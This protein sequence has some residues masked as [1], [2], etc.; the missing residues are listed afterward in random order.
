MNALSPS[1]EFGSFNIGA[2]LEMSDFQSIAAILMEEARISLAPQKATLVRSRLA[3][4]LREKGLNSYRDYIDL[5]RRDTNERRLMVEALT[6]NHTHFFR[7]SHHFD[8]LRDKLIP[9]LRSQSPAKPIR[10]WSSASS[11]GEEVYTIAMCLLGKDGREAQWA[12][13]ADL[14]LLATDISGEMVEATRK[15]TYSI[16]NA[17]AIPEPYR[18]LWTREKGDQMVMADE[19]RELVS[20]MELNLFDRWP[21]QR[22]FDAIFC[23]N[24]M[25]YFDEDAKIEL[26]T[27]LV[28]QLVPGGILYIGHS[29]RLVGP[30]RDFMI[31]CGQTI[32]RKP[33]ATGGRP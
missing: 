17:E 11:S 20:A 27:R 16:Q 25:I 26:E 6:T 5:V 13:S 29:E 10:I 9:Q 14:R 1:G 31:P 15:A 12:K 8:H 22:S 30:A 21:M 2:N 32:Y 3:R 4:R 18:K 24:V 28:D 19:A 23:R 33:E 7:E